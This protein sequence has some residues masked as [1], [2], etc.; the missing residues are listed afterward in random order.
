MNN[1]PPSDLFSCIKEEDER[2]IREYPSTAQKLRKAGISGFFL[3]AM[4]GG[5]FLILLGI[6][7]GGVLF[8]DSRLSGVAVFLGMLLCA[9]AT[10]F[11]AVFYRRA[12]A[13]E[14]TVL[15]ITTRR[16]VYISH[17]SYAAFPLSEISSAYTE[18]VSRLSR[19]PFDISALEGEYQVLCVRGGEHRLPFIEN[20]SD[21]ECKILGLLG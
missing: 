9:T 4:A 7:S 18:P 14:S 13:A 17:G 10:L 19:L 12:R 21:A 11:C 6:L 20:A 3:P 2:I 8:R 5:T 15:Y 16:V 1:T